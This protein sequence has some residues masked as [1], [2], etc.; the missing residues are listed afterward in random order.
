M[1]NKNKTVAKGGVDVNQNEITQFDEMNDENEDGDDDDEENDDDEIEDD[2]CCTDNEQA[3]NNESN[4][5]YNST[6]NTMKKCSKKPT[7]ALISSVNTSANSSET[8]SPTEKNWPNGVSDNHYGLTA[9]HLPPNMAFYA[10]YSQYPNGQQV[11]QN[12][13]K[14]QGNEFL[15]S[16]AYQSAITAAY[17]YDSRPVGQHMQGYA[18]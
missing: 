3:A 12:S 17:N 5:S 8:L 6:D 16:L 18:I 14:S 15:T 4:C 13:F 10:N 1:K 9:S 2:D 7:K 11:L